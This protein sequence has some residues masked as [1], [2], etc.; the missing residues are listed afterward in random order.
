MEILNPAPVDTFLNELQIVDHSADTTYTLE[1]ASFETVQSIKQKIT[2]HTKDH[3]AY[4]PNYLFLAIKNEDDTYTPI[5]FQYVEDF[6]KPNKLPDPLTHPVPDRRFV[7][8]E[9][10][11][12]IVSYESYKGLTFQQIPFHNEPILHIWT[13]RSLAAL[14]TPTDMQQFIGF[15]QVYFPMITQPNQVEETLYTTM[16]KDM[17][18]IYTKLELYQHNLQIIMN[19]IELLISSD[20][21][22]YDIEAIKLNHITHVH[23]TL[24]PH[25]SIQTNGLEILFHSLKGSKDL[26][27]IR[28]FPQRG[29]PLVKFAMGL[30]GIPLIAN[31]Q[32][33]K[34]FTMDLPDLEEGSVLMIKIPIEEHDIRI[35]QKG[36]AWTLLIRS[37]GD[38][39]LRLDAL[40]SN[41]PISHDLLTRAFDLLPSVLS[42]AGWDPTPSFTLSYMSGV[43]EINLD[44]KIT[45][46]QKELQKRI[47]QYAPLFYEEESPHTKVQGVS[48]RSRL[49]EG[50]STEDPLQRAIDLYHLN[51]VTEVKQV[52]PLLIKEFG[53]SSKQASDAIKLFARRNQEA[54]DLYGEAK[55]TPSYELGGTLFIE[56]QSP[57]FLF[58]FEHVRSFVELQRMLT[59]ANLMILPEKK[60]EALE[61]KKPS[62]KTGKPAFGKPSGT[63]SIEED[64]NDPFAALHEEKEEPAPAKKESYDYKDYLIKADLN[65]FKFTAS[66]PQGIEAYTTSCQRAQHRQPYV[67]SPN[68]YKDIKLKY[69]GKPV[70]ILEYPL[71]EYNARVVAFVTSSPQERRKDT[72]KT[73]EEKE[74]MELHGLRLGV[75]LDENASF[76]GKDASPMV[77]ELIEARKEQELWVF[78]RAGS[79]SPNYYIC[80]KLWCATDQLPI[81][82]SEYEDDLMRNGAKK[83]LVPS[84]PFCGEQNVIER[85][86]NHIYVGYFD[87]I[88][89]PKRYIL[90]CCFKT[91]DSVTLPEKGVPIPNPPKGL[92]PVYPTPLTITDTSTK[93]TDQFKDL[94]A[95]FKKL[96][97]SSTYF[98]KSN[99]L[100]TEGTV[101]TVPGPIDT[102]LGQ[103][104]ESY[105]TLIK[106][107]L[108]LEKNPHAFIRFGINGQNFLQFLSYLLFVCAKI[109]NGVPGVST[110]S[111]MTPYD[112]L[113]WLLVTNM[114]KTARAF[115]SANYGTL[116]H[117]FHNPEEPDSFTTLEF[118]TWMGHMELGS[119]D[120]AYVI[121]FFKAWK[122]FVAYLSDPTEIKELRIW[123]GLF[124][125]PGL[126]SKDG[127]VLLRVA[128]IYNKDTVPK[129]IKGE[130]QCP[131]FGIPK[132]IQ[133]GTPCMIPIYYIEEQ[134]IIEPLIYVETTSN[135]V[136]AIH[137][138]LFKSYSAE[139]REK[140]KNLYYQT[141]QPIVGCGRPIPPI[142]VWLPT[143]TILGHVGVLLD[144]LKK[145]KEYTIRSFLRERTN[146]LVGL[147]VEEKEIPYYIPVSD[148]GTI[149][150]TIPSFYDNNIIPTPSYIQAIA[151]FTTLSKEFSYLRPLSVGYTFDD[152]G[153]KIYTMLI[154]EQTTLIPIEV[155][156][157]GTYVKLLP[158]EEV[159][160]KIS[161]EK[162]LILLQKADKESIKLM[163]QIDVNP[164]ELLEEAYQ[165]LRISFS[166]WL[167]RTGHG[168]AKQIELLRA[169]RNRLPLYELRKRGD[170]LLH[171]LIKSW[172]MVEGDHSVS[173]LLR[174]DCLLLKEGDC[175]GMC[176]WS[177]GRCKI[178]APVYGTIE[179]PAVILTARLVDELLRTNGLA[180]EVLQAKEK[181]VSRLRTPSGMIDEDNTR[182]VSFDGRGTNQLYK[183]LGIIGRHATK[184]TQ[185][186]RYPEEISAEELGRSI[187]TESGLPISWEAAG[188]SRSGEI[189]DIVRKLP[190]LQDAILRE[191]LFT[192]EGEKIT[193]S[194]FERELQRLRPSHSKDPFQW[195]DED[196]RHLSKILDVNIILTK[197]NVRTGVLDVNQL[198]PS[199]SSQYLLLDGEALPL[200]YK[201]GAESKRF[202]DYN[203]LPEEVQI[204]LEML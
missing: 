145:H 150:T 93:Q 47:K 17:N 19:R 33:L 45:L 189:F 79:S 51:K 116:I 10:T 31:A 14:A 80:S 3:I 46:S 134:S 58:K 166:N 75:P 136:G 185:G 73:K 119:A 197:K 131:P 37:N 180:Y 11:E 40:R 176:G 171:P 5:E 49:G 128:P 138:S 161:R 36:Y 7:T 125:T 50:S 23:G 159:S 163:E 183:Q 103:S 160:K 4:L 124:S 143:N 146:R 162:D 110:T 71:S 151:F 97:S 201:G 64:E 92:E 107:N 35:V 202:V 65:L 203:E 84:C 191:L 52:G 194:T 59:I 157:E 144:F 147:I 9:G 57:R 169:A 8:E 177:D 32:I 115:E 42:A 94:G 68:K 29:T 164:E 126:F 60:L 199:K 102:L 156:Q 167:I 148:D 140:L 38:T 165:Y 130:L 170:L 39:E 175:K 172:I 112:L 108:K 83:K 90:P 48:I 26:P 30:S 61:K 122:R 54:I 95:A 6:T 20:D 78:A 66:K 105:T 184:Y 135:F 155:F 44:S 56:N 67:V 74:A 152:T 100:L 12:L 34:L 137:P 16:T 63:L 22:F 193:Y 28:Y 43:Y 86:G 27:F 76:R 118:Q 88:K 142:N 113:Q 192:P 141:L 127:I 195:S 89:H 196:L 101:G 72:S 121:R 87:K 178:H 18:D 41:E 21:A 98:Y 190:E 96:Q 114:V 77:L 173:P 69:E 174:Q 139:S 181:R 106:G 99:S 104:V 70:N 132:R 158:S 117:E 53:I 13:L 111:T 204:S 120:R 154:L 2:L 25:P 149:D 81:L 133:E 62:E 91:P 168:V 1:V 123:D 187:A 198:I 182:I 200:L 55:P 186:Y 179:D 85:K 129:I 109:G 15:F 188:W 82:E 153:A 24:P